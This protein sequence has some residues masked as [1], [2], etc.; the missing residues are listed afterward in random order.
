MINIFLI[1]FQNVNIEYN[2]CI[3]IFIELVYSF[4]ILLFYLHENFKQIFNIYK[5]KTYFLLLMNIFYQN[6]EY[7]NI[8]TN[9]TF[10]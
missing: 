3:D 2:I 10:I 8:R 6:L 4:L 5:I 7:L 9:K 1:K